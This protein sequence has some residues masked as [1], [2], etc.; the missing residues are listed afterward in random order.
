MLRGKVIKGLFLSS[1]SLGLFFGYASVSNNS[2]LNENVSAKTNASLKRYKTGIFGCKLPA[3]VP[4]PT[5]PK[6][7][8][9]MRSRYIG[10][11]GNMTMSSSKKTTI[12]L[13]N[14]YIK[15]GFKSS[16]PT[17]D[18]R[19]YLIPGKSQ[20]VYRVTSN[21]D[22][23]YGYISTLANGHHMFGQTKYRSYNFEII[24]GTHSNSED[25]TNPSNGK[26]WVL[27]YLGDKPTYKLGC[28]HILPHKGYKS[29]D[30]IDLQV[31]THMP[32]FFWKNP[33]S[34]IDTTLVNW[35]QKI[36]LVNIR[37]AEQSVD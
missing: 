5:S 6:I 20:K 35:N 9:V 8:P 36:I 32:A 17:Y 30:D 34:S 14:W 3:G 28:Y 22:S 31:G 26:H 24:P 13:I 21:D 27:Y 7:A 19:G 33:N 29:Y 18:S 10:N 16:G 1:L 12:S 15:S 23:N 37:A 25:F 4:Y 2:N 11:T